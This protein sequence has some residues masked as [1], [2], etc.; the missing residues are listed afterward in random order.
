LPLAGLELAAFGGT[1]FAK[2]ELLRASPKGRAHN[3]SPLSMVGHSALEMVQHI[4][5]RALE[6]KEKACCKDFIISGGV[7]DFLE[8]HMLRST[9]LQSPQNLNAVVGHA[10][11]FLI[12]AQK[13]Y[14][15]LKDYVQSQVDG[16]RI[17]Q[18][19]LALKD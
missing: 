15:E 2:L 8:G 7:R 16:Y 9:L 12:P 6:L 14:Q 3:L 11:A 5:S 1:N 4:R 17:A 18:E 19:F 10:Y 13:S